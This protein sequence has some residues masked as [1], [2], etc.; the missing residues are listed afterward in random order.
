MSK[1]SSSVIYVGSLPDQ[2]VLMIDT[3]DI[4]RNRKKLRYILLDVY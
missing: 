3:M 2:N 1:M 4:L